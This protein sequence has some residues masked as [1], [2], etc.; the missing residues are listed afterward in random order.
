MDNKNLRKIKK[1]AQPLKNTSFCNYSKIRLQEEKQNHQKIL[2][3]EVWHNRSLNILHMTGSHTKL[4]WQI[5]A[6]SL[7]LA[8]KS[9]WLLNFPPHRCINRVSASSFSLP[10]KINRHHVTTEHTASRKPHKPLHK[11]LHFSVFRFIKKDEK[12]KHLFSLAKGWLTVVGKNHYHLQ[13]FV[14]LWR[15]IIPVHIKDGK[16]QL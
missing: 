5:V 12:D 7:D 15:Q 11:W 9:L 13:V 10:P 14:S 1:L 4:H 6:I 8:S 3:F 2:A 16:Y